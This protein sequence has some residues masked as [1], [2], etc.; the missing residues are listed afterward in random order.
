MGAVDDDDEM[1][2][3]VR[4]LPACTRRMSDV[5]ADVRRERSWRRVDI[6][7]S[8]GTVR[9]MAVCRCVRFCVSLV[10]GGLSDVLSPDSSLMNIWKFSEEGDEDV[11]DDEEAFEMEREVRIV[12][13]RFGNYGKMSRWYEILVLMLV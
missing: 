8:E 9:G 3:E 1:S 10:V 6:V 2:V 12:G 5:G 7:V 11:D 4:C 13:E